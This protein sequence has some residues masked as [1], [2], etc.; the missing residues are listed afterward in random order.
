MYLDPCPEITINARESTIGLF[1]WIIFLFFSPFPF[2]AF[3]YAAFIY[4]HL[5]M[6]S[7]LDIPSDSF[8][9]LISVFIYLFSCIFNTSF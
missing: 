3:E 5:A 2:G 8:D 7:R 9:E 1:G 4:M 6:L